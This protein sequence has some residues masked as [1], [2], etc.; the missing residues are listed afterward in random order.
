MISVRLGKNN[1]NEFSFARIAINGT[2]MTLDYSEYQKLV[3]AIESPEIFNC[4]GEKI[5]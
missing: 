4:R 2:V 5:N 1:K 3:A